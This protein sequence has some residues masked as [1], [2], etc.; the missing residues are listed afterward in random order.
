[1]SEAYTPRTVFPDGLCPEGYSRSADYFSGWA[2]MERTADG[3]LWHGPFCDVTDAT[4]FG[5]YTLKVKQ[6]DWELIQLHPPPGYDWD[7]H[8]VFRKVEEVS[9][10]E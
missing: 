8:K 4:N 10:G 1:M 5:Q 6:K 3:D 2:V 7:E 9:D